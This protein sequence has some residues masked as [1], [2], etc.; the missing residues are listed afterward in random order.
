MTAATCPRLSVIHG[1]VSATSPSKT[2]E[3]VDIICDDGYKKFGTDAICS[4]T[5]PGKA[6]WKSIPICAGW[7]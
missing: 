2:M 4:P 1:K 7:L 5:G 6:A 3:T